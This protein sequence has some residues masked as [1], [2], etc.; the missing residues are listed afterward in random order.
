MFY[1]LSAGADGG[2]CIFSGCL[3]RQPVFRSV[4]EKCFLADVPALCPEMSG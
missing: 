2:S 4:S 3:R 1:T